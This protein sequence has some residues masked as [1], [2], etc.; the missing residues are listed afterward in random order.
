M[1]LLHTFPYIYLLQ[2]NIWLAK[3]VTNER[4]Q[5]INYP[6]G[7]TGDVY[8]NAA[9]QIL[10][11]K[12]TTLFTFPRILK[13]P[14]SF[15]KQYYTYFQDLGLPV[16]A[17]RVNATGMDNIE[18]KTQFINSTVIEHAVF[19]FDK[20]NQYPEHYAKNTAQDDIMHHF[21]ATTVITESFHQNSDETIRKL[22]HGLTKGATASELKAVAERME[23]FRK[24]FVTAKKIVIVMYYTGHVSAGQDSNEALYNHIAGRIRGASLLPRRMP[25]GFQ[26]HSKL[27]REGD[28]DFYGTQRVGDVPESKR[29]TALF[30]KAVA[31]SEEFNE[32]VYGI[33]GPRSGSLDIAAMMGIRT[34]EF[35]QP[36]LYAY[37]DPSRWWNKDLSSQ[38]R[39]AYMAK[40]F[41]QHLRM[42]MQAPWM[43][44]GV[45]DITSWDPQSR[46]FTRLESGRFD[47]WLGSKVTCPKNAY[48]SPLRIKL[49]SGTS[50]DDLLARFE[51]PSLGLRA[52]VL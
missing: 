14:G 27:W 50:V 32:H 26:Q 8:H 49:E 37:N 23:H 35:D 4:T 43:T 34:F 47:D 45:M 48:T 13:A 38:D 39:E 3:D 24:A 18:E 11:T 33:V 5:Y 36:F 17:I 2:P 41:P 1:H 29:I 51:K 40:E 31:E 22:K 6:H 44:L 16:N 7:V 9:A 19:S 46:T 21:A 52:N 30:W 42:L 28:I 25:I 10:N 20:W 15:L 12:L